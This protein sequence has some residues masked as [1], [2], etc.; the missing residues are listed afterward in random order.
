MA[1]RESRVETYLKERVELVGG[2]AAKFKGSIRGE[3]DRLLSFPTGYHCLVETKW[4]EGVEP[5]THQTRRHE[6][7]RKRGMHVFVL[8]S[9]WE[10][11]RFMSVLHNRGYC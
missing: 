3:P 8:R 9:I 2:A 1:Q 11:D 6:W 7:W 4:K 10:V 5:K